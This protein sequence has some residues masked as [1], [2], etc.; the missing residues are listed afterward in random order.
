MKLISKN[1]CLYGLNNGLIRNK[2]TTTCHG[3]LWV[4]EASV[5]RIWRALGRNTDQCL[6]IA[7]DEVEKA[8]MAREY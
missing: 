8:K 6:S 3:K 2:I 5:L 1:E 4:D 7:K